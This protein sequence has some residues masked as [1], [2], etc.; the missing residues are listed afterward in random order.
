MQSSQKLHFAS[1]GDRPQKI[2]RDIE[3]VK[4][5]TYNFKDRKEKIGEK[6]ES[7]IVNAHVLGL[8]TW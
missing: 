6:I 4:F 7:P 3:T 1:V 5:A 2:L 8:S